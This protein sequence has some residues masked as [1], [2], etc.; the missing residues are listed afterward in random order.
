MIDYT[1]S[2]K[3][4]TGS[5]HSVALRSHLE[6]FG[7]LKPMAKQAITAD[8]LIELLKVTKIKNMEE[9]RSNF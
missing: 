7:S 8:D 4:V 5:I 6:T 9:M 2:Q 1:L 3:D